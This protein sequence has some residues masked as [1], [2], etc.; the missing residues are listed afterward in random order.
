MEKRV[1]WSWDGAGN[2][3][4]DCYF[5]VINLTGI[6]RKNRGSL[7]YPDL[8]SARR[9]VA[10]C[11][12]I[13]VPVFGELPDISDEDSSGVEDEVILDEDTPYPFSQ[14]ELND[15]VRD[16]GLSKSSVELLASRLKEKSS[17]STSARITF[18]RNRHEELLRWRVPPY[19]LWREGLGV[20]YG[21]CTASAQAWSATVQTR[22]LETVY[23]Q[24]QA[25][26]EMWSATQRQPVCLCTPRSIDYAEGEV[27]SGE[28]RAG[29][30]SLWSAW[31]GHLCWP[32]DGELSIWTTVRVH[33]V[34]VLSVH[35]E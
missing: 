32:E 30:N 2:H 14:I 20:L 18:Y 19:F 6:N 21:Y 12:E 33:Q 34:P 35:V 8:Q 9:L 11:D 31:V 3:G 16:L 10:H 24:Q 5:C 25:I 13:P 7:K 29:E 27:W 1:V 17:L 22:N 28:V 15:L 4:T 23:W 26:A